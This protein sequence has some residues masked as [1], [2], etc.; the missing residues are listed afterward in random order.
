MDTFDKTNPADI[1]RE[2]LHRLAQQRI[3][4]T[5]D[6]YKKIYNQI[7]GLTSTEHHETK[8]PLPITSDRV[9]KENKIYES[10]SRI[11]RFGLA[12]FIE[13]DES[14]VNET[15]SLGI[16]LKC[17]STQN[18]LSEI[19]ERLQQLCFKIEFKA[20]DI[21]EE[22][23]LLLQLF[24]LLIKNFQT[25]VGEESWVHGQIQMIQH[26]LA[27][28]IDTASLKKI[29]HSLK[30]VIYKQGLIKQNQSEA[31]QIVQTKMD[32]F[33]VHVDSITETTTDYQQKID[34]YLQA[35]QTHSQDKSELT[36]LLN[37]LLQDTSTTHQKTNESQSGMNNAQ[38]EMRVAK[39]RISQLE[40]QLAQMSQL[41]CTDQLTGSLNRR[42]LDDLLELELQR[43]RRHKTPLCIAMLDLDNFKRLNDNYG[44]QTGDQVLIHLVNVIK[45][46]LRTMDIVA[47]FGGEEFMIILSNT[48]IQDAVQV[49]TRVQRELTKRI[50]MFDDEK[51]LVTFSAGVA[52]LD[53]RENKENLIKRADEALYDAKKMGK[54][55]VVI[56]N[57]FSPLA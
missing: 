46:T 43:S 27:G 25:L 44:H 2:T 55:R 26:L 16:A 6:A 38:S 11:L 23:Q 12:H 39:D 15:E 54:N 42:G 52:L 56:A 5:P 50:F 51:L 35:M 7:I 29:T 1:A 47:R 32:E 28:D 17:I 22:K 21:Q 57:G 53:E 19:A 3:T 13:N 31:R 14:L 20:N 8:I 49:V 37:N 45:D 48:D 33:M 18:D 30:E 36:Q 10:M 41:V 9:E 40:S 34:H 4:P 24:R